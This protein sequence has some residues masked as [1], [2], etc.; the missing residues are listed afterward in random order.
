MRGDARV[1]TRWITFL[2]AVSVSERRVNKFYPQAA[3]EKSRRGYTYVSVTS[4]SPPTF[5]LSNTENKKDR[6]SDRF[7]AV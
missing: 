5:Q 3:Q 6:H 2:L 4:P 7:N 1:H